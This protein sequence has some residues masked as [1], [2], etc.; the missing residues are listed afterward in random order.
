MKKSWILALTIGT[1]AT[2]FAWAEEATADKPAATA[3]DP[4]LA[5]VEAACIK[6]WGEPKSMT[7]NIEIEMNLTMPGISMTGEGSGWVKMMRE[8]ELIKSRAEFTQNMTQKMGD[9][10]QKMQSKTTTVSDG[11]YAYSLSENN[12]QKMCVKVDATKNQTQEP[13]EMFKTLREQYVLKVLPDEKMDGVD[14]Y[15]IEGT[16]KPGTPANPMMS[17]IMIRIGKKHGMIVQ[18]QMINN[19]G[20]PV[21]S[22]RYKDIQFDVPVDKSNFEFTPPEGVQVIDQTKA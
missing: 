3:E 6:A 15:V 12:G 17:K 2:G 1:I 9:N 7:A 22:M 18:Q 5:E 14:V 4:R 16:N 8:G 11:K 21:Q 10:E 20:K 19:E 13:E